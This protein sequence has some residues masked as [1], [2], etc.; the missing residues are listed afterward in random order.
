MTAKEKMDLQLKLSKMIGTF[1]EKH[2]FQRKDVIIMLLGITYAWVRF[3]VREGVP[4]CKKDSRK[5]RKFT[6]MYF[7]EYVRYR[8]SNVRCSMW[9]YIDDQDGQSEVQ[10]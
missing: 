2:E 10:E 1:L 8:D 5:S 6:R 9:E 3:C 4:G 7:E